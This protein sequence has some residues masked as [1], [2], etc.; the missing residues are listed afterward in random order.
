M[1]EDTNRLEAM[2]CEEL[3]RELARLTA[4]H[5]RDTADVMDPD[6]ATGATH[7]TLGVERDLLSKIAEL[8]KAKGCEG[9]GQ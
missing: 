7:G 4:A 1:E 3:L 2:S 6:A 5:D 9:S 8:I